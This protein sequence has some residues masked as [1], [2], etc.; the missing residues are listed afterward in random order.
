MRRR[1]TS[2]R[3]S[4][5]TPR[6]IVRRRAR[7]TDSGDRGGRLWSAAGTQ[8][9]KPI[10]GARYRD[11]TD[12]V[13]RARGAEP[14]TPARVTAR[15]LEIELAREARTRV[16]RD[17]RR[18][19]QD[20][21]VRKSPAAAATGSSVSVRTPSRRRTRPDRRRDRI[22]A[23]FE[24]AARWLGRD[25]RAREWRRRG[26]ALLCG[27]TSRCFL[28]HL[29]RPCSDG[30]LARDRERL[31]DVRRLPARTRI[32]RAVRRGARVRGVVAEIVA[33]R[34]LGG[35][36]PRA[37]ATRRHGAPPPRSL[38]SASAMDKLATANEVRSNGARGRHRRARRSN[39]R[40]RRGA[41]STPRGSR[42]VRRDAR[43]FD[44]RAD[45]RRRVQTRRDARSVATGRSRIRN[46]VGVASMTRCAAMAAD[47]LLAPKAAVVLGC[48]GWTAPRRTASFSPRRP[49]QARLSST[50]RSA[51]GSP[52]R[53]DGAGAI[54][55]SMDRDDAATLADRGGTRRAARRA[56]SS[57][58]ASRDAG[59]GGRGSRA[60]R[61]ATT[62]VGNAKNREACACVGDLGGWGRVDASG[63]G[64]ARA[65]RF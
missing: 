42:A 32:H 28:H 12:D 18:G 13:R 10:L 24:R 23:G 50:I 2:R 29:S 26:R 36:R 58:K 30:T 4:N 22:R 64:R 16:R 7:R 20:H 57:E 27:R 25:S 34:P 54:F 41:T 19:V 62:W 51:C 59:R 40:A 45:A 46:D 6:S 48:P 11:R 15:T 17:V 61:R 33:P 38:H 60:R 21:R 39:S 3:N 53:R 14:Y 52:R 55:P 9:V 49:H 8:C 44:A 43:S 47:D 1:R 63:T 65:G 35:F 5:E 31:A 56:S 37:T